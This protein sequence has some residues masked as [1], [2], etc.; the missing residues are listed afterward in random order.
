MESGIDSNRY[1]WKKNKD[2]KKR[3]IKKNIFCGYT[4]YVQ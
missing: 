3:N 1:D 4:T 2:K